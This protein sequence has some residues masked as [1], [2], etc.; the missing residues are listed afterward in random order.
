MCPEIGSCT[1]SNRL[2]LECKM[3]DWTIAI[4]KKII[5]ILQHVVIIIAG[6]TIIDI[7]V[8]EKTTEFRGGS[9]WSMATK[10]KNIIIINESNRN[11]HN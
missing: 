9:K 8:L 2:T 5:L 4:S 7:V 3:V 11:P 1:K 6:D 10:L